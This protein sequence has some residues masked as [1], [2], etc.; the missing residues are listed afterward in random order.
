MKRDP[1]KALCAARPRVHSIRASMLA[2]ALAIAGFPRAAAATNPEEP[3]T[4]PRPGNDITFLDHG[5]NEPYWLGGE[6][7]S[8]PLSDVWEPNEDRGAP[9]SPRTCNSSP[10]PATTPRADR[11]GSS[12]CGAT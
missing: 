4:A 5:G 3:E 2:I 1:M 6:A 11:C 12:R 8:I 10:I 7:N 9:S